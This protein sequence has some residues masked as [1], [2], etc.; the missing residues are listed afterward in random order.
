MLP[1]ISGIQQ[2]GLGNMDVKGTWKWY[3]QNFGFNIPIF[4]E[5]AVAELMLP[6]TEGQPQKRHAVL[7]INLN[8]GG[9]LE[10]WQFTDRKP[11]KADFRVLPG[12]LGIYAAN[13]KTKNVEKAHS[14]CKNQKMQIT[15][16]SKDSFGGK[17]FWVEDPFGNAVEICESTSWFQAK[18]ELFGGVGGAVIG[19]S[20]INKSI[21]FYK[22]ILGYDQIISDNTGTFSDLDALSGESNQYR[23]AVL[24]HSSPTKGPFSKLLGATRITLIQVLDRAPRKIYENRCWGDPGWIHLC[25]D[26]IGMAEM[27]A[28]CEAAGHPFTVDS[29]D[30]F[31]MG[32]AAGHFSYIEDPDGTLI[33][34][35]ETHKIPILKKLNWYLDVKKRNPEKSLP[36]WM[37]KTLSLNRVKD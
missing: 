13:I 33:E 23:V 6:Y 32:E 27:K 24:T 25:F 35:V 28:R 16:I 29:T 11:Q 19:V 4:E 17:H 8:G 7:A 5:A 18:K 22:N 26:I 30:G 31:D 12:D 34:F 10:I 9:G 14:F 15:A 37:L 1:I 36:V 2:V 3:R 20:D 21:E